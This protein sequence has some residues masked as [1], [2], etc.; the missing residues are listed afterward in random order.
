MKRLLL[1]LAFITINLS[2][3]AG[4]QNYILVDGGGTDDL[5]LMLKNIQGKMIHVAIRNVENGSI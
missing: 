5:S 1:I 3:Y 2:A 4:T